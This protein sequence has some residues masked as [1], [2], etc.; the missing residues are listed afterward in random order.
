MDLLFD[1]GTAYA[2]A[3][4]E[5][6]VELY[7]VTDERLPQSS[8][9]QNLFDEPEEEQAEYAGEPPIGYA[10]YEIPD[11]NVTVDL[12]DADAQEIATMKD[13]MNQQLAGRLLR[14]I[15]RLPEEATALIRANMSEEDYAAFLSLLEE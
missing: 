2:E 5:A 12:D 10:A 14:A 13:E 9:T 6:A 11:E 7:V 4:E 8:L 15:A 3:D 1:E